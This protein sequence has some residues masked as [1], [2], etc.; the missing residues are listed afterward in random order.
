[1]KNTVKLESWLGHSYDKIFI[2]E[3]KPDNAKSEYTVYSAK[4]ETEGC[5][6]GVWSETGASLKL[7]VKGEET[8]GVSFVLYNVCES[9]TVNDKIYTDAAVP[10]KDGEVFTVGAGRAGAFLLEFTVC[11]CAAAGKYCYQAEI[12]DENGELL[13]SHNVT[14]HVWDF[15][16][17]EEKTFAATVFYTK[18]PF[19]TYY[20]MLAD[21]NFCGRLLPVDILSDEADEYLSSPSVTSFLI[22]REWDAET[23]EKIYKK[24]ETNPEWIKKAFFY[25]F[26]EPNSHEKLEEYARRCK[27][28]KEKYPKIRIMT[29]YYTN[30]QYNED[31]DQTEFMTHCAN[32]LCPKLC[33][34]DDE[35]VYTPEQAAKYPPF[36]ERM[37]ELQARG[38]KV[39]A[40][41]CNYPLTSYM[42]V[43][44]TDAGI[45]GRVLFWQIYQRNI[46][47]FLYWNST[48]WNKL[49]DENPW[50]DLNTT[51]EGILG[52][53][54]LIYPD[55]EKGTEVPVASIRLKIM[56]NGVNDVELLY[57]AEKYLGK[58][59]TKAKT[60]EVTKSLTTIE[61]T[62]DGFDAVRAEIGNA[63]EAAVKANK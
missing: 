61:V 15:A 23:L 19:K 45:E 46:D 37:A 49:K 60:D 11:P 29:P 8:E 20:K 51:G 22:R 1:M 53:G 44:L 33:M 25:P 17:P 14:L 9:M 34:W 54:I 27:H 38:D 48:Y 18:E 10:V 39:W 4:N 56:R 28:L 47:G 59:W 42:N 21:H 5:A 26:D 30:F 36:A 3:R 35:M 63:I 52:D 62:S 12:T 41:V 24:L 31:M 40:Y 32:N 7:N 16:M 6:I 43:R 50:I 2:N 57:L 58:E 55:K 13:A